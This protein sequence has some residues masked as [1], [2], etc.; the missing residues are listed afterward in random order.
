M[1]PK[2]IICVSD[3]YFFLHEKSE[4]HQNL[5]VSTEFVP[6]LIK[7][8]FPNLALTVKFIDLK[9]LPNIDKNKIVC[10]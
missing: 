8:M 3:K 6:A 10:R 7:I 2:L 1:L 9:R 4:M 5:Y